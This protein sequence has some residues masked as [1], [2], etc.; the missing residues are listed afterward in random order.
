E[1]PVLGNGDIWEASDAVAM[2]R[3][4]GCDGVVI[5]RGC[6]GRP[7]LFG[8]LIAAL[9]GGPVPGPRLLGEASAAMGEHARLLVDH[10]ERHGTGAIEE[11]RQRSGAKYARR[12]HAL[13]PE[14]CALR[15]FRKHTGWYLSGYPVGGE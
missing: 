11:R 2:L 15:D 1:I 6:L 12:S 5:G 8:D 9:T 4:T 10:Y 13:T 3:A 14:T 7:W